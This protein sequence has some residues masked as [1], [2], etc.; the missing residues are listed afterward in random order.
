MSLNNLNPE[1]HEGILNYCLRNNLKIWEIIQTNG[2]HEFS[3]MRPEETEHFSLHFG[4]GLKVSEIT[5]H[6]IKFT[7]NNDKNFLDI[8]GRAIEK[9]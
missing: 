8:Y 7:I 2:E 4:F 5:N 3:V 9:T 1:L 6:F